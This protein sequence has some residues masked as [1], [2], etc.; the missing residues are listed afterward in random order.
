MALVL[1]IV[2]ALVYYWVRQRLPHPAWSR[3][4]SIVAVYLTSLV[5]IVILPYLLGEILRLK[6]GIEWRHSS[7]VLLLPHGYML[8]IKKEIREFIQKTF[9]AK[10]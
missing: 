2:L 4:T 8:L 10:P 6:L 3:F 1:H 5:G 7:V 9:A